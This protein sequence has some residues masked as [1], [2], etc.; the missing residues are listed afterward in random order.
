MKLT[1]KFF[2][3]FLSASLFLVL[4]NSSYAQGNY[5]PVTGIFTY[6][7]DPCKD[8]CVSTNCDNIPSLSECYQ[9]CDNLALTDKEWLACRAK[10]RS[11]SQIKVNKVPV[12]FYA[13]V[14]FTR[15][16]KDTKQTVTST[17]PSP[18]TSFVNSA[19][20]QFTVQGPM[21]NPK[22]YFCYR[23]QITII[24]SDGSE[25]QSPKNP[26]WLCNF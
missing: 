14:Q 15:N 23:Y 4:I 24:Y 7:Y 18:L 21:Y 19:N 1:N 5:D 17:F 20:P 3:F 16:D 9:G 8:P 12:S 6:N 25:C 11:A 2:K 10:C 22:K 26:V 13:V